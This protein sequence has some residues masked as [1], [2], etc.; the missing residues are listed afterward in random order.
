MPSTTPAAGTQASRNAGRREQGESE[1]RVRGEG[2]AAAAQRS[3]QSGPGWRRR[4]WE[5]AHR[6]LKN[7]AVL[8]EW[9]PVPSA[10]NQ[11]KQVERSEMSPEQEKQLQAERLQYKAHED[12]KFWERKQSL[13]KKTADQI[14][15]AHV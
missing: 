9:V 6:R 5:S 1:E 11:A 8:L 10:L 13:H 4:R 15:R 2:T 12:N 7:V 14:G 3:S